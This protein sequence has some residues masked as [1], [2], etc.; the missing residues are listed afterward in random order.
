MKT[1]NGIRYIGRDEAEEKWEQMLHEMKVPATSTSAKCMFNQTRSS[2]GYL[3]QFGTTPL[4]ENELQKD[5]EGFVLYAEFGELAR[6]V[7]DSANTRQ[8]ARRR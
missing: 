3:C 7:L 5:S 8:E 1:I 6:R 4:W 2:R